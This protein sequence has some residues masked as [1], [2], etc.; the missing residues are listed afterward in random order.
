MYYRDAIQ[1]GHHFC[2]TLWGCYKMALGYGLRNGGGIGY[3]L[4]NTVD[5]RW[6]LD[7]SFFFVVNVGMLN[8]VAGV[9]ITTFGQLREEQARVK[10]D[11]EGVCFICGIDRQV[12]DRASAEPEGFKTHT[13]VDHN[14]WN[15]LYFIFMLWEQDKD[16]DDG[17]EQYVRRAI[18]ANEI[19]WFPL[20]KAIRLEQAAS[21]EEALLHDLKKSVVK[22][23]SGIATTLD[24]FQTN[25]N[26]VLEQLNQALKQDHIQERAESRAA[27]RK[28]RRPS[29]TSDNL[30]GESQKGKRPGSAA[31]QGKTLNLELLEIANLNIPANQP[32]DRLICNVIIGSTFQT[33]PCNPLNKLKTLTFGGE[34]K[35]R[36]LDGV[37]AG[38]ERSVTVQ[39]MKEVSNPFSLT[40]LESIQIPVNDL[41]LAE[42]AVLEVFFTLRGVEE[43]SKL[44]VLPTCVGT[45][46]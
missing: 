20:N 41:L 28:A 7:V 37:Q 30:R 11:T 31:N 1:E 24:K 9:I 33:I 8:L 19:T 3:T 42:D 39:L 17:L 43:A 15:Y 26:I 22:S 44:S 16:D 14:M 46:V 35:F 13:K 21:A 45:F 4:N 32:F 27:T 10:A 12:F 6:A 36:L 34:N 2:D 40:E 5:L 29:L 25:I 18:D 38:D 23:E